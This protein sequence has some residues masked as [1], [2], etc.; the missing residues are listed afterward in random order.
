MDAKKE[1]SISRMREE[2]AQFEPVLDLLRDDP[3]EMSQLQYFIL[4]SLVRNDKTI[5]ECVEQDKPFLAN[6]FTNPVEI[7]T[8]MDVPFYFHVRKYMVQYFVIDHTT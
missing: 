8:A 3:D 6:Q 2:V 7:C 5:I 4:E 1:R